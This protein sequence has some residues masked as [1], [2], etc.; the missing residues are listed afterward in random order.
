[1]RTLRRIGILVVV[2]AV[3]GDA[4]MLLMGPSAIT[5]YQTP[6]AGSALCNCKD[7]ARETASS[8]VR[9]QLTGM[10]IGA[11]TLLVVGE[12]VRY[13]WLRRKRARAAP[14]APAPA[15]PAQ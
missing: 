3:L 6:A 7:L 14:P 5:W 15:P 10:A 11:V 9:A 8:L 1:V 12:V 2:G 4:V 13:L